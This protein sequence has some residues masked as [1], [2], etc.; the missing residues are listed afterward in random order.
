MRCSAE[1]IGLRFN[2]NQFQSS[3]VSQLLRHIYQCV[4]LGHLEDWFN[5]LHLN[6]N[7]NVSF[8][9]SP[10]RLQAVILCWRGNPWRLNETNGLTVA[11]DHFFCLHHLYY[12]F[13]MSRG[14]LEWPG[15]SGEKRK[16][17][18]QRQRWP[19]KELGWSL[20]WR[21]NNEILKTC[22]VGDNHHHILF[23]N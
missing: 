5:L 12:H 9:S 7:I 17:F 23:I 20:F 18:K 2:F 15:E 16:G 4:S 19:E 14:Q 11:P 3:L 8:S 1:S 13:Y 22:V 6:S 10:C 21:P